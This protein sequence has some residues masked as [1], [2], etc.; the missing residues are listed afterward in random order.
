MHSLTSGGISSP[1]A[2]PNSTSFTMREKSITAWER[3]ALSGSSQT[4]LTSGMGPHIRAHPVRLE[5]AGHLLQQVFT[6]L[7]SLR[8]SCSDVES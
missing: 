3:K 2:V 1:A 7:W 8:Q 6:Q 5:T 4:Q